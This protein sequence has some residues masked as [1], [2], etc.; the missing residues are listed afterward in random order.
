VTVAVLVGL[1][2]AVG[3]VARYLTDGAVQDRTAGAYPYGT[4]VV[5]LT[6]SLVLGVVTGLAWYHGLGGATHTVIGVG[7]CGAFTTWSTVTWETVELVEQRLARTAA[8]SLAVQVAGS[9]AAAAVGIAL[10]A[11]L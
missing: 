10:A 8:V 4:L 1:C 11:A 2:G 3:A 5:N 6:G 9:L 7:L